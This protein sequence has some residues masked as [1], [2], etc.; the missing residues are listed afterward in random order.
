MAVN[1]AGFLFEKDNKEENIY[2]VPTILNDIGHWINIDVGFLL[3][4]IDRLNKKKNLN[5]F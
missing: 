4:L 1:G 2:F 5:V 3:L